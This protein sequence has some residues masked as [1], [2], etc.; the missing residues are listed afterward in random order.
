MP[1]PP[2]RRLLRRGLIALA[3]VLVIAGA[4]VAYV[5]SNAPGNVSHPNVQF[6]QPTTAAAPPKPHPKKLVDNFQW[7]WY[8]FDAGRTRSFAAAGTKL[9]PPLHVGWRFNDGALL[10]FPPVIYHTT[11]FM[12]DDNGFAR[13]INTLNGHVRWT[14]RIGTLAAASP[15]V[16]AKDQS[17]SCRSSPST[18]THPVVAGS[19]ACP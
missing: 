15:A 8:G 4:V 6:T 17:S 1:S 19:S 3:V 16:A 5:L 12:L 2:S 10:E 7:P 13:A 11:L 18:A 9:H 14:R